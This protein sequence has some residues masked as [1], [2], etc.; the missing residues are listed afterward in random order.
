MTPSSRAKLT[1]MRKIVLTG[2][3]LAMAV[4]PLAAGFASA[5]S[6]SYGY[7]DQSQYPSGQ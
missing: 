1:S 3:A 4:G 6:G 7:P 2:G 5:Q